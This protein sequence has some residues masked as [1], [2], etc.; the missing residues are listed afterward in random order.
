MY[1]HGVDE[2]GVGLLPTALLVPNA[3]CVSAQ[4]PRW[5]TRLFQSWNNPNHILLLDGSIKKME[6]REN[7]GSV[8]KSAFDKRILLGYKAPG[9]EG[10]P[11]N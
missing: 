6:G 10:G 8:S 4:G 2:M 11:L 3:S 7:K 5:K 1:P 9:W